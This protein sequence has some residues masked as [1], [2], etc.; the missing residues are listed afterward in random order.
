MLGN[1]ASEPPLTGDMTAYVAVVGAGEAGEGELLAAEAAG[2]ALGAGGAVVVC[3]GLSG[4]MEAAA[5]GAARAGGTVVGLLPGR[6][7]GAANPHLT[8]AL[9]TGLGEVRNTLV[10]RSADA[11]VAVGGAYG[12]L[13][14]IAFALRTGVPVVG[15]GTWPLDDVVAV[16]DG[17][18][19]AELALLLAAAAGEATT[20]VQ[21]QREAVVIE[22]LA[23]ENDRDVDRTL[24]TFA[25]P[26]YEL[27]GTG[28]VFDGEAAVRSYFERSRTAFPDQRND[29]ADL[30]HV[31]DGVLVAF[32]LLG[33]HLGALGRAEPTGRAFRVRMVA[34]F[35]FDG[36]GL[37]RER[38]WFDPAAI[39]RQLGLA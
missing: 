18:S 13:S 19:A 6:D 10:V 23:A 16:P 12:T 26:R 2:A 28:E 31:D 37:V 36:A 11:V 38:V 24:A 25:H 30:R 27:V 3:G 20:E 7:R 34:L 1:G 8:V 22:H 33:T 14:E 15:V 39:R 35:G 4:V 17:G 32:D 5:R 21:A 29:R 9:A